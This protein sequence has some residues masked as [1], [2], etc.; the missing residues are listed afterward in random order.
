MYKLK[1][2]LLSIFTITLVNSHI[3]IADEFETKH[4]LSVFENIKYN[5]NFKNFDYVNPNAP[6]GGKVKLA[7]RGTFDS[8]NQFILKGLPAS[9]LENIY[10]SLLKT[11]LDEPFTAYGLLAKEVSIPENKLSVIFHLHP[12]AKWSDGKQVTAEDVKWTFE[13]LIDKGHPYYKSYYADIKNVE[14]INKNS[15]K[16]NFLSSTNR[17]LPLIIGQMQIL[18]KHFWYDKKF[19][20]SGLI[21]PI[22]SGPYKIEKL[23]PG[24]MILY[25][26]VENHWAENLPV[27]KGYY[28]FDSIQYDYYRDAYVMIEALKAKQYDFRHE[29]ISKEWATSYIKTLEENPS[30]IKEEIA[31]EL[32]QGM[33][34]F[35]FNIRKEIFQDI[36]LRKA[37]NLAFDFEWTNKTL[38]HNQYKRSKSYFSNSILASD[39]LPKEREL[40]ILKKYADYLPSELFIKPYSVSVTDGSGNNRK[41]LRTAQKILEKANYTI[42]NNILTNSQNKNIEF[43]IL[44]L[45]PAFERIVSPFINNLLKLGIKCTQRI[46]DTAQYKNRLDNFD[47][48]MIVMARGQ[49]LSPGNEQRN[50]WTSKMANIKGSSNWIGIENQIVD[51]LVEIVIKAPNKEELINSTKA[52]D[53]VLLFNHYLV[54][55]WHIKKWRLIYW[56]NIKRPHNLPKYGL[57]FPNIWWHNEYN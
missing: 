6:I 22:G 57:G 52:L 43:E 21:I 15:V 47:F 28:N 48:D 24:K 30:F 34:A 44:L 36:N 45:S 55:H 29:N 17:E 1:H 35:I 2:F 33:Q 4:A 19:T 20:S 5:K 50:Y 46:V 3:S 7:E 51:D 8:L 42:K 56:N 25:K 38:F 9:G 18:P 11:S 39:E 49:S 27:N 10:Q 41:N 54:P 12:S 53:R 16:F 13:T 32:P 37:I 14:I 40:E 26:R 23:D 31:H